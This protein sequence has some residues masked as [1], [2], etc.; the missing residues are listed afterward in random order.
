MFIE[1]DNL[2]GLPK[3]SIVV[4]IYNVEGYLE[5]CLDS[6]LEQEYDNYE[7]IMVDDGSQDN[8]SDIMFQYADK[9]TNF[10]AYKKTNGGLGQA[11][12]FGY[13][14]VTGD[15]VTFVDSDD[16]IP[17]GSYK[18]MM[19][20]ILQT[21]SDFIIGN[22]VRFNST[23]EFPS[24]LHKKVFSENK[25]KTHITESPELLY[26]TT[27]WNKIYKVSF[28][29]EHKFQFPE[30]MLYEDIPVTIPA[31]FKA[32]SVDVLTSVVYKWRARDAGDQSIT[33][34]RTDINNLT[35]RL[36]ALG[37]VDQ[38][39]SENNIDG[40]VKEEKDYKYLSID[41]LVYLNQLDKADDEYINTYLKN[42]SEYL[43]NVDM[44]VFKKLKVIDRLKYQLVKNNEK[45]EL[46]QLLEFQKTELKNFRP[47]KKGNVYVADY[48][49]IEKLPMELRVL[50]EEFE[51]IKKVESVSWDGNCL[52]VKGYAYIKNLNVK[53][54][55]DA[56]IKVFISD[57]Q[58][59]VKIPVEDITIHKRT[60][61]T[62][63]R[64]IAISSKIPLK[65]AF[66]YNWSG[67]E[68]KI[69]FADIIKS[70]ELTSDK[71]YI[72]YSIKNDGIERTFRLGQPVAGWRTKPKYRVLD[73]NIVYPKY[74]AAWDIR[75]E[76]NQ[77]KSTVKKIYRN[78]KHL[79]FE[80][81][82]SFSFENSKLL[83]VNYELRK[84]IIKPLQP[85]DDTNAFK[86]SIE[87]SKLSK[88]KDRGEW[89]GHIIENGN[90]NP[91]TLMPVQFNKISSIGVN[92]IE[93][94]HSPA[95]NLLV[96][97]DKFSPKV[98]SLKIVDNR[99]EL[100]IKVANNFY[101]GVDRRNVE[102]NLSIEKMNGHEETSVKMSK[103]ETNK[104]HTLL[105]F[106][107][108]L[109]QNNVSMFESGR[110]QLKLKTTGK[111]NLENRIEFKKENI[112]SVRTIFQDYKYVIYRS[113]K[114][115]LLRLKVEPEWKWIERGPRRQEVI[116]KVLYPLMRLLPLKKKTVVFESYWGKNFECNPRAV[117]E[118]I[119]EHKKD[120]KT[121]WFLRDHH[122]DI[123]G[124]AETVRINSL[125]YYYYLAT[126]KYFVNNVNFPDFYEKRK[127]VTEIQTM[128]GIPLKTLGLDAPGEV[129][130]EVQKEKFLRRCHRWDYLS[131]PSNYVSEIAKS[132]YDFNNDF[133]KVGYPRNDKLFTDNNK[134]SINKIKEKMG[135]PLDKK[136][137]VYVPTWRTKGKF[138]MPIDLNQ[139]KKH[140]GDEYIFIVKL[141]HFSKKGFSLSEYEGFAYDYSHYG[142]IRDMYLIAD[143]LITDYSSVM[144]DYSLLNKPMLFYTYDYDNYKNKLRG[145]YV[146]F[147]EEAPGPLIENTETLVKEIQDIDMFSEKYQER[148]TRFKEKYNQF[149]DGRASEKIVNQLF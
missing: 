137:I 5:E 129:I 4:P 41:L 139:L 9:Y 121:V 134:E 58:G 50:E 133:L 40:L 76:V 36:K 74:N 11:R 102:H 2:M 91:L 59:S 143:I 97:V 114:G 113:K 98:E 19:N 28:W 135:I 65:R 46:L 93:I 116:K 6:L 30:A 55:S 67:F 8:S 120:Y 18:M 109:Y 142:D 138:R 56:E 15:Y 47:I 90:K 79:I 87:V 66:N 1:G 88:I 27:A 13:E 104:G 127:D 78:K 96:R 85:I 25:L 45:Q 141:H 24:V 131:V 123:T 144:F 75:L 42:V 77:T 110:W 53:K 49:Y 95:G 51:A 35:D 10:H 69:N 17:N 44:S 22:V 29:E 23:K 63:K 147:E 92:E 16:I 94:D 21:E 38:Y 31:H 34:Q 3:L 111:K 132:A 64:G 26:D 14:F 101:L 48:P 82:T 112:D 70:Y 71:Y 122:T 128:H 146:D 39:F 32:K 86:T 103:A 100:S 60:D 84:S 52:E 106:E 57:E 73:E 140:F 145:M 124:N 62:V 61:I 136:V 20:T 54:K 119:D 126:A 115:N 68:I 80:G 37:M 105:Y 107:F 117:Y 12:N 148:I 108:P 89:F 7:V 130:G 72:F 125:K 33:Q 43:E 149:D 83:L 81:N 99:A 118:Y